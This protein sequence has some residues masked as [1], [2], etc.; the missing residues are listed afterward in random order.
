MAVSSLA[1]R[2]LAA[3]TCAWAALTSSVSAVVS[4][5]ASTWPAVTACP[6]LT[7]TAVT[8]PET[9]KSRLAWLAGSIVPELATVDW[10][11]P[12][13]TGTVVVLIT[14]P[15]GVEELDVNQ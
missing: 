15:V 2:A 13:V 9:A 8:F 6:A 14:K 10:I 5:V 12:V 7:L 3:A 11:V 4:T 1:N